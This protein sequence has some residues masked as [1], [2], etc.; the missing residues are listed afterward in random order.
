MRTRILLILFV[1]ISFGSRSQVNQDKDLIISE[2][3]DSIKCK[4][5]TTDKKSFTCKINGYLYFGSKN[6]L[7]IDQENKSI[8][9]KVKNLKLYENPG[10]DFTTKDIFN[11][12][13]SVMKPTVKWSVDYEKNLYNY[14]KSNILYNK[15]YW[16][17]LDFSQV[18]IQLGKGT[19][20]QFSQ[21]FFTDCNDFILSTKEIQEFSNEF[22][23]VIDTGIVINRNNTMNV[24]KIYNKDNKILSIDSIRTILRDF[25]TSKQGIGLI[26][27]LTAINKELETVT[28]VVTF[29]DIR[30]K[31][32]LVCLSETSKTSGIGMANHWTAPIA[33]YLNDLWH[34]DSWRELY[35]GK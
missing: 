35:S 4:I 9:V 16:Y 14:K 34:Y 32:V 6:K 27:F 3:N 23:F 8:K 31:S 24:S 19:R 13:D 11:K 30:S 17:G 5:I 22:N 18:K 29:F 12:I 33:E 25:P 20:T 2:N 26:V 10:S 21:P 1:V 28:Y 7:S 15:I